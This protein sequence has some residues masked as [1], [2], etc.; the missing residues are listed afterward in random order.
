M[1]K[2]STDILVSSKKNIVVYMFYTYGN[3]DFSILKVE[4]LMLLLLK[5]G[6]K[7]LLESS[8]TYGISSEFLSGTLLLQNSQSRESV[9]TS[10]WHNV[11]QLRTYNGEQ[12][13]YLQLR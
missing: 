1:S 9:P 8:H 7:Q 10:G 4:L 12:Q 3:E 11:T 13:A 6:N 2:Q 5:V